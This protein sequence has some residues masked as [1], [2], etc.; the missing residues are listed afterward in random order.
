MISIN[1]YGGL[2]NQ[3]FQIFNLLSLSLKYNKNI[4]IENKILE[5]R[6]TYWNSI[7]RDLKKYITSTSEKFI[8]YKEKQFHYKEI[9]LNPNE[10]IILDGY[11]QSYKYFE[12]YENDIFKIINLYE[13]QNFI[14][15]KY[16]K[17]NFDNLISL[18]FRIGDYKN[19]QHCHNV[20]SID[21]YIN[22][23]KVI[24]I[25]SN[26]NF[27][28]LCFYEE[29]DKDIVKQ[30]IN[31]LKKNF[32]SINFILIDTTILDYE[33]MLLMSLMQHNII[34]NS[35]FSWWGAYLNINK[36]KII[37][38]PSIWFGPRLSKHNTIDLF[39]KDWI[40]I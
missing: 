26:H 34:A 14:R 7:L 21:Y 11:F 31:I 15:K 19:I 40:K 37:T 8:T 6:D 22:S 20:L 38:Y 12:K 23:L 5:N 13:Q 24:F 1:Y 35:T 30:N 3:L 18:H 27:D 28:V 10:N 32:K 39:P 9:I 4:I 16:K 2:G 36:D 17:Y 29:I 25:N 33:Q